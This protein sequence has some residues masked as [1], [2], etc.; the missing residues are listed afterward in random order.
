MRRFILFAAL[1]GFI[2]LTFTSAMGD[3][4]SPSPS[5]SPSALDQPTPTSTPTA[6]P[7]IIP[8]TPTYILPP[9]VDQEVPANLSPS[10]EKAPLDYPKPYADRC[11][12]QQNLTASLAACEYGNLKSKTTVVLFGDSHA[13]SWFPAIEKLAIAKD[14]KL[15][16]LT[17]SSCWPADIPAWNSTTNKLMTNCTIWRKSTLAKISRIKPNLI[18]VSGTGGFATADSTGKV[19]TGDAKTQVWR[20]GIA[21]TLTILKT[22]SP[23]V[24]VLGDTPHS[25]YDPADCLELN[26]ESIAKCSTPLTKSFN[27]NWLTEEHNAA[28]SLNLIWLDPTNWICTTDPCSPLFGK[29][30]I[31]RDAGHLTA[32]FAKTLEVPLWR[33]LSPL[34]Q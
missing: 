32:T 8:Y 4:I 19:L 30:L 11:H 18:F 25:Q 10:L 27:T 26:K 15:L 21:R 7:T 1:A 33:T 5:T 12:T 31:Y 24:V 34:M 9:M 17:M 6:T 29:Y 3:D 22:A 20:A 16:S 2:S 13:L 28:L 14:W 23:R